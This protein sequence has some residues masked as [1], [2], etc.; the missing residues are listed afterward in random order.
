MRFSVHAAAPQ[1]PV[2]R[3]VAQEAVDG[4]PDVDIALD[5][6]VEALPPAIQGQANE[7]GV[8]I[9][10]SIVPPPGAPP[11]AAG[12]LRLVLFEEFAHYVLH[13]YGV[14]HSATSW[15]AA[16]YQE[17]FGLWYSVKRM[18]ELGHIRDWSMFNTVPIPI[19]ESLEETAARVGMHLGSSRAGSEQNKRH[20]KAWMNRPG[21]KGPLKE[22]VR[23]INGG[24]DT[25]AGV[26]QVAESLVALW[27]EERA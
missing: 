27:N 19:D 12:Q 23:R 9:N 17:F 20:M 16:L 13:A 3:Q 4:L 2:V 21:S 15:R 24:V 7:R 25:S 26:E 1:E 14:P 22:E 6:F 10:L 18:L 5:V 8:S 11:Q